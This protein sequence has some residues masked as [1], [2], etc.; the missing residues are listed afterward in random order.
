V[1]I[2]SDNL[3]RFLFPSV[4]CESQS[5]LFR[6]ALVR[7][8]RLLLPRPRTGCEGNFR[9]LAI[10]PRTGNSESPSPGVLQMLDVGPPRGI[11]KVLGVISVFVKD[12]WSIFPII[13]PLILFEY[14]PPVNLVTVLMSAPNCGGGSFL[15]L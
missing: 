2:S 14:R 1:L 6:A 8:I 5:V 9:L 3:S 10:R 4:R 15:F 7:F 12:C 11:F 13:L